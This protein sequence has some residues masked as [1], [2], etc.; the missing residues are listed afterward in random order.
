MIINVLINILSEKFFF[1]K[2]AIF[3]RKQIY[4]KVIYSWYPLNKN[5]SKLI[6][7]N[8]IRNK[9]P[10]NLFLI[11]ALIVNNDTT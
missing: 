1:L 4:A 9:I 7:T 10:Y 11:S 6:V 2:K 5:R 3:V 8:N